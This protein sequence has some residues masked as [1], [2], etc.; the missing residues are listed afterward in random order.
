MVKV[1]HIIYF[2]I[3][4][5]LI[6][7]GACAPGGPVGPDLPDEPDPYGLQVGDTAPDFTAKDQSNQDVSLYD[8]TGK[9]VLFE[10]SADW[11]GPCRNEAPYLETI[12]NDY[13]DRGFQV[14]TILISGN[15]TEW[16]QEYNL[17]FPVLN[18]SSLTIYHQYSEGGVPLNIVVDR[19]FVIRYKGTGFHEDTIRTTIEMY[20]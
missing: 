16:A 9:V 8:Y 11:C 3:I 13:K 19:N 20:L 6:S 15:T 18:D 17:T 4:S 5:C 2:S 7:L 14:I 10:F 12:Y 1:K